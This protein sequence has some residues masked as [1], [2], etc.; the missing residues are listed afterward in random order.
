MKINEIKQRCREVLLKRYS[1]RESRQI[2]DRL[3]EE[4]LQLDRVEAV[5]KANEPAPETDIESLNEALR[6]LE[7]GRPLDYI[8]GK[9]TF[10]GRDFRVDERV[11]IPRPET[12]ELV[13]YILEREL[14][15]RISLLDIGTGSGCI[16]I[17]LQLE[18]NYERVDGCELSKEALDNAMENASLLK[19]EVALF[20]MDILQETPSVKYDVIVSNPP[21][22][23]KEEIEGLESHVKEHEPLVALAPP[24]EPLQFYKRIL[25]I[26]PQILN[27]DGR[28]YFEIHEEMGEAV[29][30]LMRHHGLKEVKV[31][32]DLYG[33]DRIASGIYTE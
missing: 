25:E 19:A 16:P 15:K 8:L 12:E 9:T 14:E 3:M 24:G 2:S 5:L 1:E 26:L 4:Y 21:Y 27:K 13:Q 10:F 23:F 28:L 22:V 11:L 31:L 33:R 29:E 18:A 20:Q 17:T 32:E 6:Q 30:V 7:D